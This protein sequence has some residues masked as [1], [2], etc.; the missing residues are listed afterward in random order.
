MADLDAELLALA[1][2]SSDDEGAPHTETFVK[3][4]TSPSPRP[5][6]TPNLNESSEKK[7]LD[8]STATMSANGTTGKNARKSR[9][10]DSE[11]EGEA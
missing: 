2:D 7:S 5:S 9:P 1:G 6:S 11:E 4:T 10:N 3:P 8:K